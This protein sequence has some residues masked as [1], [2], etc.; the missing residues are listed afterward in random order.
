MINRVLK[1]ISSF[2]RRQ[3]IGVWMEGMDV[4]RR[5]GILREDSEL[6]LTKNST[7]CNLQAF[8][9]EKPR[10]V[11]VFWTPE[12]TGK[13]YTLSRMDTK[14]TVDRRFVYIDYRTTRCGD[15]AKKIFYR[16]IGLDAETDIKPLG[17]YLPK[18]VFF[19]FIF[20]HFDKATIMP[21]EMIS[22][23]A[24]DSTTRSPSSFNILVMVDDKHHALTLLK[25]WGQQL[26]REYVT[27]L[28]P[29]YC[30]RWSAAELGGLSDT[31]YDDLVEQCGTLAPMISI[32]NRTCSQSDPLML[33]RA[34]KLGAEWEQGER[35]LGQ[36][37]RV[38]HGD[39]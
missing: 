22:T 15:D 10:G 11:T 19:T 5:A 18:D 28:G 17:H 13:T 24:Q 20:D 3:L 26:Q 33:L 30:G 7:Y 32:R 6:F 31:R 38:C 12:S 14:N 36:Y 4:P 35:L 25:S 34:A 29:P 27:L 21:G 1:W 16:H 23:L 39:V 8:F 2:F 37:R 9:T